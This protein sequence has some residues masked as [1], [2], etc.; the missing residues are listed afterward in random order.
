VS[1]VGFKFLNT[2]KSQVRGIDASIAATT[3]ETN[4]R[5]GVSALIGYTYIE[6][7]TLT[8]DSIYGYSKNIDGSVGPALNYKNSSMDTTDNI[9]KYRFKHMFKMDIE[10][11]IYRFNFGISNK[12][13]TKMQNID[14]A[15]EYIEDL[16]STNNQ[17]FDVIYATRYWKKHLDISIWD[18][19]LSYNIDKKQKLSVVCNN[20]FNVEYSLRP[21]KI[22]SPRT[23]ALQYVLTF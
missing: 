12:Y 19:R 10:F 5:F 8:P 16:T 9:L 6:P 13:Y 3:P 17:F 20:V 1:I 18:A 4:K 7:I 15:F 14:K 22:E 23:A 11:K 21:L 2:G